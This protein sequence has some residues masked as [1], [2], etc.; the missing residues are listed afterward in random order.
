MSGSTLRQ[1]ITL[2]SCNILNPTNPNYPYYIGNSDGSN[3]LFVIETLDATN[4]YYWARSI[5]RALRI[6]NKVKF[7][8]ETLKM[9][10]D[11]NNLLV[12]HWLQCNNIMITCTHNTLTLDITC[13]TLYINTVC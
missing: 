13:G 7:I 1:K 3:P 9:L 2:I 12:D 8:D 6:K 10:I 5:K 11:L 4:Y